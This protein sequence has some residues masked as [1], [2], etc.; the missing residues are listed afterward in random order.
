MQEYYS[1]K[2]S[3]GFR[4]RTG[5]THQSAEPYQGYSSKLFENHTRYE[6]YLPLLNLLVVNEIHSI[7]WY[8]VTPWYVPLRL[9]TGAPQTFRRTFKDNSL[10]KLSEYGNSEP[11]S[12]HIILRHKN[13][14]DTHFC[15]LGIHLMR[16]FQCSPI[17]QDRARMLLSRYSQRWVKSVSRG[18][19]TV[20]LGGDPC[21]GP[22]LPP[23]HCPKWM[24][25]CQYIEDHLHY[26]PQGWWSVIRN[27]CVLP[28]F[29]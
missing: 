24:C 12:Q 26:K 25:P 14:L 5:Y 20:M 13:L 7:N 4:S 29:N 16:K 23:R 2:T 15:K 10:L 22:P 8:T 17:L 9:T 18:A 3:V 27:F 21:G 1:K 28:N 6:C 11:F 19:I